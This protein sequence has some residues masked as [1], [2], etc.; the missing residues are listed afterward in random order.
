MASGNSLS[1]DKAEDTSSLC[2]LHPSPFFRVI[3]NMLFEPWLCLDSVNLTIRQALRTALI[4]MTACHNVER[5]RSSAT[6]SLRD[7]ASSS[8]LAPELAH[9]LSQISSCRV[10][11]DHG[12]ESLFLHFI[13]AVVNWAYMAALAVVHLKL[14]ML[15]KLRIRDPK[16][17]PNISFCF[18]SQSANNVFFEGCR[19]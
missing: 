18:W 13:M 17:C 6:A 15:D 3:E 5:G 19:L 8:V 2:S 16:E 1:N 14:A 7:Q 11:K 9:V 4:N 10:M 12:L